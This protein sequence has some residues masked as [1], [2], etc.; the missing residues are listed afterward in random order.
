MWIQFYLG[1]NLLTH[2][3]ENSD[4]PKQ[5]PRQLLN[6]EVSFKCCTVL[7]IK[8][9]QWWITANLRPLTAHIYHLMI[10]ATVGF[11]E[12]VAWRCSVKKVFLDILQN[13]QKNSC[14]RV[15]F[16]I[17]LQAEACNFIKKETSP[18]VFSCEFYKISRK[19]FL[20]EHLWATASAFNDDVFQNLTANVNPL[21]LFH[22]SQSHGINI[23]TD[24]MN[25]ASN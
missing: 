9:S 10:I 23:F 18:K 14:A 19:A 20:T 11:L 16:S 1:N 21:Q 22:Y 3:R 15:S 2:I 17:K 4:F 12:A 6:G 13:S 24:A 8:T 5:K 7:Q 25:L